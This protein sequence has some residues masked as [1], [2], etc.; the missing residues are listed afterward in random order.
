MAFSINE[1]V[2]NLNKQGIAKTSHFEVYLFG[3]KLNP[4]LERGMT[5]RAETCELPGRTI[6]STEHRF[7]NYGPLNKVPYGQIYGD[8]TI[9]FSCSEDFREK[10][11]FEAWQDNMVNTGAFEQTTGRLAL[12]NFNTRYFDTYVGKVEIRQFGSD[13]SLRTTHVLTEAYPLSMA[14]VSMNWSSDEIAKLSVTFAFRNYR[15]VN[16]SIQDQSTSGIGFG[17]SIGPQGIS[18]SLRIPGVGN[19]AAT[20]GGGLRS[21]TGNL[22]GPNGTRFANIASAL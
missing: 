9:V 2:S 17:F 16:Y 21:V 20:L 7:T 10:Y 12:S 1:I 3:P 19:V 14:P 6:S 4:E 22:L 8:T 5:F 11:Y 18:G 15:F 13:G